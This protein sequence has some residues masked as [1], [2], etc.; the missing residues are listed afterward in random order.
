MID[1]RFEPKSKTPIQQFYDGETIFITGGTGFL[2][3]MLIEKLV[4]T[5]TD[6]D[7]LY[8]LVR[9]KKDNNAVERVETMFEDS[10]FDAMKTQ[11]PTW[12]EKIVAVSGDCTQ[13]GFE[14]SEM[15]RLTLQENT[16]VV[17]HLAA[18]VR[19][20]EKLK[21][22]VIINVGGTKE[23]LK[24]CTDMK[25]LKSIVHVSTAFSN[26][27]RKYIDEKFYEAP[28]NG[29]TILNIVE[30]LKEE[31]LEII[32][33]KFVGDF[34]NTYT[35]TKCIAEHVVREYGGNLPIGIFR[36]A[37][38]ISSYK[39]P[40]EGWCYHV[41]GPSGICVGI[42]AGLIRVIQL[43]VHKT[44]QII[45]VDLTVN[46]LIAIA[47]DIANKKEKGDTEAPI[48]NYHSSWTNRITWK[49]YTD[50]AFKF[51]KQ[52]PSVK[53]IW[54][55]TLITTTNAFF[56]NFLTII[57]HILPGIFMDFALLFIGHK[58]RITKAYK[59]IHKHLSLIVYF[60]LRDWTFSNPNTQRLWDTLDTRDRELFYFSMKDFDWEDYMS[61]YIRGLRLYILQ[62]D[63][64]TVPT[65]QKRMTKLIYLHYT[66][67]Y[68]V[69]V[70]LAWL[71]YRSLF[72]AYIFLTTTFRS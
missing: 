15:D 52:I 62:E 12:R 67:K 59:K 2:G 55:Y 36:P 7:R 34:P 53:S 56:Y 51:G 18:T 64:N 38:V 3:K 43:D 57:L 14:L 69:L 26:C 29:D 39:E 28:V 16:S 11:V 31:D 46:A 8:V 33:D 58:P 13:P 42:A 45:P 10:V 37:I 63:F 44:A 40:M 49:L 9:P 1:I 71:L 24:M 35:Y 27:T 22:A 6:L 66:I 65:A 17:F 19:F 32:A 5:C 25:N 70:L 48:Y 30:H 54:C 41:Y 20:D 72:F 50:L 60:S 61:K 21:R 47:W 23:L 68:T 4:R